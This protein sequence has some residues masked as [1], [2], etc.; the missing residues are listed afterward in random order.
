MKNC[1]NILKL[2]DD[3]VSIKM[4]SPKV[5]SQHTQSIQ[6]KAHQCQNIHFTASYLSSQAKQALSENDMSQ[7][8]KRGQFLGRELMAELIQ[9]PRGGA[10]IKCCRNL[11]RVE[12][13]KLLVKVGSEQSPE[14]QEADPGSQVTVLMEKRD[15]KLSCGVQQRWGYYI[16]GPKHTQR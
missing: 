1:Q 9:R 10:T 2:G 14:D 3:L 12:P 13:S 6:G 7:S 4:L 16:K 11:K 15:P 5:S 8:S